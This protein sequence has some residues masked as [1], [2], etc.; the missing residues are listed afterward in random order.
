MLTLPSSVQIWMASKPV[1]L[2]RGIDSLMALVR[3]QWAKDPYSWHLFVFLGRGRNR[4]KILYWDRGGFVLFYNLR[5][6]LHP[7]ALHPPQAHTAGLSLCLRGVPQG[8]DA[9]PSG[10]SWRLHS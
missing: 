2:R 10:L 3:T 7:G 4:V 1:D 5:N 9:G 6:S 8:A